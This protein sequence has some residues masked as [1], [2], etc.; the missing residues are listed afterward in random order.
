MVGTNEHTRETA[1]EVWL[2]EKQSEKNC[3]SMTRKVNGS[4]QNEGTVSCPD[5]SKVVE[6]EREEGRGRLLVHAKSKKQ[7]G[8]KKKISHDGSHSTKKK[9]VG[10]KG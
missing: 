9:G 7:K 10:I 5:Q 1:V 8:V 6:K 4:S 3:S 2:S